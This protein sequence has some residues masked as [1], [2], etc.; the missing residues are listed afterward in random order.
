MTVW[1][2]KYEWR[3]GRWLCVWNKRGNALEF[4][5]RAHAELFMKEHPEAVW[6]HKYGYFERHYNAGDEDMMEYGKKDNVWEGIPDE[7]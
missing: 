5:D 7:G 6:G 2:I 4:Y 1:I 3:P